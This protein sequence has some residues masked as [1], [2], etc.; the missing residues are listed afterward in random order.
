MVRQ[1]NSLNVKI[2]FTICLISQFPGISQAQESEKQEKEAF[3]FGYCSAVGQYASKNE[4]MDG[5]SFDGDAT[6]SRSFRAGEFAAKRDLVDFNGAAKSAVYMIC[7][8]LAAR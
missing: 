2:I 1:K 4:G 3:L 5:F 8:A 7:G 6:A